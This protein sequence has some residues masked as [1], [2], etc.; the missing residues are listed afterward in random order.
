MWLPYMSPFISKHVFG[1]CNINGFKLAC[2]ATE[3]L[4][5]GIDSYEDL[6]YYID[7]E[8]KR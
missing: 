5:L 6:I 8:N 2:S 4:N 7:K 3:T 1:V